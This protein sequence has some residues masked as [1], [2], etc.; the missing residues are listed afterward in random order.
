MRSAENAGT[1]CA[2]VVSALVTAG[3]V[4]LAWPVAASEVVA[5]RGPIHRMQG[6]GARAP[7]AVAPPHEDPYV[8]T[9][10]S[11]RD[12][13]E[14]CMASHP[15]VQ[16]RLSI[17]LAASGLVDNVE[18]KSIAKDLAHVD[19]KMV[20]CIETAVT[21]LRFPPAADATRISTFLKP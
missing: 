10:R 4:V 19:L 7:I 11:A 5:P 14:A 18:V 21:R 9:L 15:D 17:D 6:C 12:P 3:A 13:L 16:V 20:K 8:A 2:L 1:R